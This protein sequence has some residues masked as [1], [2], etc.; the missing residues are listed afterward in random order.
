MSLHFYYVTLTGMQGGNKLFKDL[1]RAAEN[2]DMAACHEIFEKSKEAGLSAKPQQVR[3]LVKMVVR[4]GEIDLAMEILPTIRNN[5]DNPLTILDTK[6]IL[7]DLPQCFDILPMK[8]GELVDALTRM[9]A[10]YT[11]SSSEYFRTRARWAVLE[12]LEEA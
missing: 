5:G 9:T 1:R 7:S 3:E 10:F 12:F 11:P 6:E 8:G 2:R 4:C